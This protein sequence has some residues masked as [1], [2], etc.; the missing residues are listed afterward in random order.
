[1]K[2]S[3]ALL[4]TGF[5]VSALYSCN[6][7]NTNQD[8]VSAAREA[9]EIEDTTTFRTVPDLGV[10]AGETFDDADFAIKAAEGGLFEVQLGKIA[11]SRAMNQ[12]V[13]DFANKMVEDH[14]RA[15]QE[16]AS[17]AKAK[18]IVLPT[19][20]GRDNQEDLREFNEKVAA[21]FDED[22]IERMIEDH[23]R[24]IKI[25]ERASSQ[26]K[27]DELK[28]FAVKQLPILKTHL[29]HARKIDDKQ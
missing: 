5:L 13:K 8:S 17:L 18:N 27:D 3:L 16:L 20:L 26:S 2:T 4:A 12:E 25:F 19:A 22:Y 24:T 29:E 10:D 23:E 11:A 6:N 7:S 14:G 21:D 15:N 9:N 1:M 28:A